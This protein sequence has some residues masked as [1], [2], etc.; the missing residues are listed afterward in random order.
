MHQQ[1][2]LDNLRA[3]LITAEDRISTFIDIGPDLETVKNQCENHKV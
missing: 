1:K 3:W 2:Q